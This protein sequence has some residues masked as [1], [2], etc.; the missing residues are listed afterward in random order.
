MAREASRSRTDDL[1]ANLGRV[2]QA[3]NGPAG[4]Q[5]R[6]VPR[7]LT[8][9]WRG[10][11]VTLSVTLVAGL[12]RLWNLGFPTDRGT[13]VFD[14]KYY[15]PQA[16]QMIRNGGLEDNAGYELVVH[17][18]LGKQLIALGEML[19]GYDSWGWRLSA[20]LAG[21]LCVL[22][23]V[24]IVRRMTRSTLLGGIAGVLLIADGVS[25]VQSRVGMLDI[26]LAMLVLAAFGCLI[27][28]RDQV[29]ARLAVVVREGRIDDTDFGPRLGVRWWRFGAGVLL[30]MACATKWSGVYYLAAFA[31]LSVV[32]DACA[33]RTA[34]VRRPWVGTVVRDLGP[35]LWAL[36]VLPVGTYL[37]MWWAWFGSET[38]I[39]RHV[40]G[41]EIGVGGPFSFLP[42][43]LRSLW[44]YS[45][46]V[47]SFH[48]NL[49]TPAHPHPWE[50]KPWSWPMGLRPMLYYY[51][52]GARA[53]GCGQA[54]CVSAMMLIGTPALWWVS[55]PVLSWGLWRA[56]STP[57]WRFAAALVGYGAGWLPW[58]I[59]IDRQMF[60][61]YMTP[62]APF[63]VIAVALVLGEILG[64]A[65]DGAERR[66][67]GLLLVCI[68]VGLVVANFVWLW[69]ILTGGS[70]TPAHWNSE[71]WLPSW[72]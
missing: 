26:F 10:W 64:R 40:V 49:V 29:Y 46:Q 52:S 11:S 2:A 71:L 56:V 35:A 61:F 38:G 7:A 69:P 47:L 18:P 15:A 45:G 50:S 66:G 48:E 24:R 58:F 62:A 13:P 17:P 31:V 9:R 59:K 12:V 43:A 5:Q 72:R 19:L 22:L 54:D 37:A 68:Y 44:Y 60:F 27:V 21:T 67:T 23:I 65:G 1:L 55:L 25:Q 70:I 14:E 8:D 4:P 42:D 39:D 41:T 3:S 57:D 16:W 51:E 32:W 20:A 63:L 53:A 28:D 6:L 30:G 36:A 34:G 33:R